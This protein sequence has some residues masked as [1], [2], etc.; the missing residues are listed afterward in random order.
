M[1]NFTQ[2]ISE[3]T[4]LTPYYRKPKWVTF[5][6]IFDKIFENFFLTTIFANPTLKRELATLG[7][8]LYLP[9]PF[10]DFAEEI[11]KFISLDMHR[12][13]I[14]S[15][16]RAAHRYLFGH[17]DD[18]EGQIYM[19]R[20]SLDRLRPSFK[21]RY[22]RDAEEELEKFANLH[23]LHEEVHQMHHRECERFHSGIARHKQRSRELVEEL[24]RLHEELAETQKH[25]TQLGGSFQEFGPSG[26]GPGPWGMADPMQMEMQSMRRRIAAVSEERRKVILMLQ[27]AQVIS[28]GL[29]HYAVM[30]FCEGNVKYANAYKLYS[31]IHFESKRNPYARRNVVGLEIVKKAYDR[32][33]PEYVKENLLNRLPT[34]KDCEELIY[35]MGREWTGEYRKARREISFFRLSKDT[36]PRMA[37]LREALRGI[38]KK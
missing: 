13:R 19:I 18:E 5:S 38:F 21:R 23:L 27:G 1:K 32:Y 10:E 31:K 6:T 8:K 34:R 22:G 9:L 25:Q 4:G 2:Q 36:R 7:K 24:E 35:R 20:D 12:E 16:I 3:I 26:P 33:D 37:R 17:Y 15:E 14:R 28:E 11:D 29:A 30:K